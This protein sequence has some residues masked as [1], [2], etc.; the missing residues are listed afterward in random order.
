MALTKLDLR[1]D[2]THTCVILET[3]GP[4][5]YSAS[6]FTHYIHQQDN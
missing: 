4:E 5:P 2:Y 1:D 6:H 3:L